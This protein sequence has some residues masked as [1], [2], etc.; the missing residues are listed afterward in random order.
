MEFIKHNQL[1]KV[2]VSYDQDNGYHFK[3]FIES[4]DI[5]LIDCEDGKTIDEDSCGGFY[6]SDISLT[7]LKS[8]IHGALRLMKDLHPDLLAEA[9]EAVN[10]L[11]YSD[12]KC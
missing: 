7:Y 3:D 2:R 6:D 10:E 11:E 12:I 4:H 8:E 9:L 5:E 1:L